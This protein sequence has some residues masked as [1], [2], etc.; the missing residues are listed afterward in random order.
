MKTDAELMPLARLQPW[1][2]GGFLLR[3]CD[4]KDARIAEL[5]KALHDLLQDTQHLEHDCESGPEYCPVK[6]ARKV[7]GL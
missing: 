1:E 3:K 2:Y 5:E 4:E 7:L 6:Q